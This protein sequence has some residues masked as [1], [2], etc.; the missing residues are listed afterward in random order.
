MNNKE[1]NEILKLF[2][3]KDL[4][5]REEAINRCFKWDGE[6]ELEDSFTLFAEAARIFPISNEDWDDPSLA[7]TNV[8][9]VYINEEMVPVIERHIYHYSYRGIL[10]SMSYLLIINTDESLEAYKR[11]FKKLHLQLNILPVYYENKILENKESMLTA[12]NAIIENN[13]IHHNWYYKYYHYLL[14]HCV[15]NDYIKS[16]EQFAD[17]E[18]VTSE[19]DRLIEEYMQ[20][21]EVY[22]REYVYEAWR[23]TY[24]H[25]RISL[26]GYLSIKA[27]YCSDAELLSYDYIF[28]W[29]DPYIKLT[30]LILL[31]K[32]KLDASP[33]VALDIMRGNE[34]TDY[35]YN[36]VNYNKT[37]TLVKDLEYQKYFVIE[38]AD[39]TFYH[40]EDGIGKFPDET[41]V[42]DSFIRK[43]STYDEDFI[44][45]IVRF[46]SSYPTFASNGWMRMLIGPFHPSLLPT[47]NRIDE[48]DANFTDFMPWDSQPIENHIEDFKELLKE[49]YDTEQD[50]EAIYGLYT[51]RFNRKHIT[52]AIILFVLSILSTVFINNDWA[53]LGLFTGPV[54][55]LV[56]FIYAKIL[57][58]NVF[59]QLREHSLEYNH[60][61]DYTYTKLLDIESVDLEKIRPLLK[62]RFLFLPYKKWHFVFYNYDGNI[63][64]Q[65]PRNYIKEEFFFA[66]FSESIKFYNHPP[67]LKWEEE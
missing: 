53:A 33:Q 26:R 36:I 64:Y 61:G 21:D 49:S 54:W 25:K 57:E 11:I 44:Y 24:L 48:Y 65:I 37:E 19:L 63:V 29:K 52:T 43:N 17:N 42:M 16:G 50:E 41:E 45:Y 62:D 7:L 22:T 35:A 46:R 2:S 20:Y 9:G 40:H 58:R 4:S 38:H 18:F 28:N 31:W 30:Y 27:S 6:I 13:V 67:S 23:N 47:P 55:L 1:L 56:N 14:S 39:F 59:V 60:F 51:P 8:A 32:R 15:S 66:N 34:A 12:L 5:I 10:L 3:S